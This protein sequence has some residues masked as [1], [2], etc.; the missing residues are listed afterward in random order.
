[1]FIDWDARED[2]D[3]DLLVV[4]PYAATHSYV[5]EQRALE[6]LWPVPLPVDVLVMDKTRFDAQRAVVASLPATV[7]REGRLL[8]GR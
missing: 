7:V 2:S 6:S 8:Y 1:L 4:V 5:L 3:F